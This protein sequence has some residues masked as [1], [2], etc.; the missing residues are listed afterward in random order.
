MATSKSNTARRRELRRNLPKSARPWVDRLKGRETTWGALYT[1]IFAVLGGLIAVG[2]DLQ[3]KFQ[4]GQVVTSAVVARVQFRAIDQDKTLAKRTDAHDRE[5]AVYVPNEDYLRELRERLLGLIELGAKESIEQIPENERR[6]LDLTPQGLAQL[7]ALATGPEP[8]SHW[9]PMTDQ[10]MEGFAGLAVL[11]APRARAERDPGQRAAKIV[12]RHPRFGELDKYDNG[13]ISVEQDVKALRESVTKLAKEFPLELRQTVIAVVMQNPR[14]IYQIDEDETQQRRQLRLDNEPPVEMTYNPGDVLIQAGSALASLDL[15]VLQQER[16]AYLGE[17]GPVWRW[18]PVAGTIALIALIGLGMWVYISAYYPRITANA[19]RGL[20]ITILLLIGQG[21]AV[22]G[23]GL[24]P[25]LVFA[26]GVFPTLLVGMIL[27]IAYDQRFALAMGAAHALIVLV[28]LDLPM[29]G[30]GLG[31]LAGIGV[32]IGQLHDVRNRSTLVRVGL[33]SGLAMGAMVLLVGL[34]WRPLHLP[35]EFGRLGFDAFL[36]LATGF[37]TGLLVQGILPSIEKMFNVMTSMT[38]RELNDASHPLLRRLAQEAPGTY[39]HSL[40][41]ADLGEAAAE[42]IGANG[43]LCKVGAMYHDIGKVNKPMY[44][45]ENQGG[46]PNRHSKLSPAMSLLI[47]VGHVKDGIEMAREYSLPRPLRHFIESHHG[48]TLVEYFYHAAKQQRESQDKPAPTEFEFRYPGPKPQTREAAILMLCD[49][50]ESAAR[51]LDDPTPARIEQLV[52]AIANKR[53]MDGQF[54]ECTITL[55]DVH[56]IEQ[57]LVKT[58][59]AIYHS[60]VKYPS[61]KKD[62]PESDEQTADDSPSTPQ[63]T[64]V[65]S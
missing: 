46:G 25:K 41:I 6:Q 36:A 42:A 19:M 63:S 56:K 47:I 10:F 9:K 18:L 44:F 59:C 51:T 31:L 29:T 52:H 40:R 20:A 15:E 1:L 65:A 64:S 7:H 26:T 13:L 53:L 54:D 35:G 28:S 8:A 27:A 45:V 22:F 4:V 62:E 57:S 49:N 12:I 16:A 48:T 61:D 2:G 55:Q 11:D 37:A 50:V 32:A 38:L 39:Q 23:T 17:L 58:L 5:P 33:S 3:P 43:L 30:F 34:A 60:R 24:S 21:L 14:P